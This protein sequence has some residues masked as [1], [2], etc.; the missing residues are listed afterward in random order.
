MGVSASERIE[1]GQ[2]SLRFRNILRVRNLRIKLEKT[3]EGGLGVRGGG[4]VAESKIQPDESA[5]KAICD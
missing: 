2:P 5:A 4:Q 1:K 3:K